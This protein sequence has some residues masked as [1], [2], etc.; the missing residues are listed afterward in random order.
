MVGGPAALW[1]A[2]V[3]LSALVELRYFEGKG[4]IGRAEARE[5]YDK[6]L[7][8]DVAEE[9]LTADGQERRE[10]IETWLEAP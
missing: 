6:A 9:F 3:L 5:A 7:G 8:Q 2:H 10:V 4:L 1:P